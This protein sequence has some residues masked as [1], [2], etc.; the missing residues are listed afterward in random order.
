MSKH[1]HLLL[2]Y[3]LFGA[4]SCLEESSFRNRR[5]L[6]LPNLASPVTIN[7]SLLSYYV[8]KGDNQHRPDGLR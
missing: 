2:S 5:P 7:S 4:L 6:V 3:P 8:L 1:K